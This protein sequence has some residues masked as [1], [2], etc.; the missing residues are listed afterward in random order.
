MSYCFK[1]FTSYAS[2]LHLSYCLKGFRPYKKWSLGK[3]Q[4]DV[5]A[6]SLTLTSLSSFYSQ[7]SLLGRSGNISNCFAHFHPHFRSRLWNLKSFF[8]SSCLW[9]VVWE[10]SPYL[11][12]WSLV[13]GLLRKDYKTQLLK[14]CP[15]SC[16]LRFQKSIA[17]LRLWA[18]CL[19]IKCKFL[20][21]THLYSQRL[22]GRSRQSSVNMRTAL[23]TT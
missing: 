6:S 19:W 2:M 13:G 23:S 22:G 14:R 4:C 7:S 3:N 5:V 1:C 20:P 10:W 16:T 8:F 18:F 17:R 15:G 9:V 11:N 12:I 21:G